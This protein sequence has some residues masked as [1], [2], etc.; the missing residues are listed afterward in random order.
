MP[1]TTEA[2][3][4]FAQAGGQILS[5]ILANNQANRAR[6]D[7]LAAGEN[8]LNYVDENNLPPGYLQNAY[9]ILLQEYFNNNQNYQN[10]FNGLQDMFYSGIGDYRNNFDRINTPNYDNPVLQYLRST[11]EEDRG[12]TN[13]A[14]EQFLQI[15][16]NGG[17]TPQ[18]EGLFDTFMQHGST[19]N[20]YIANL[21]DIG[22]NLLQTG[23][24]TPYSQ[25]ALDTSG[26]F[27]RNAG[28]DPNTQR[29]YDSGFQQRDV[30]AGGLT[31]ADNLYN[32]GQDTSNFGRSLIQDT[33]R[34]GGW[35]PNTFSQFQTGQSGLDWVRDYFTQIDPMS[36]LGPTGQQA[37]QQGMNNPYT[38][39]GFATTQSVL[40][41]VLNRPDISANDQ[42]LISS[43]FGKLFGGPDETMRTNAGIAQ[44]VAGQDINTLAPWFSQFSDQGNDLMNKVFSMISSPGSVGGGGGATAS[45]TPMSRDLGPVDPKV[46]EYFEKALAEFEKNPLLSDQD[47][48]SF[49]RDSASTAAQ[50][51]GLAAVKKA[52]AMGGPAPTIAGGGQMDS[53]IRSFADDSM[54]AQSQAMKDALLKNSELKL[55]RS[56]QQ[57]ELARALGALKAQREDLFGRMNIADA[58]N[59]TQ[60]SVANASAAE[61]AANR[62]TQAALAQAQNNRGLMEIASSIF[63]NLMGNATTQRG[64]NVQS[65]VAG[66]DALDS[67]YQSDTNRRKLF[68]DILNDATARGQ[69]QYQSNLKATT[70]LTG[71]LGQYG[72]Q[73]NTAIG[74]V[75]AALNSAAEQVTSRGNTMF[76]T[77]GKLMTNATDAA[78]NRY[79]TGMTAGANVMNTGANSMG[80]GVSGYN[81]AVKNMTDALGISQGALGAANDRLGHYADIFRTAS[82][83]AT[84]RMDLG[85]KMTGQG[86]DA[87]RGFLDSAAGVT[88]QQQ[89]YAAA[90]GTIGSNLYRTNTDAA[91]NYGNTAVGF[92]NNDTDNRK[93][94]NDSFLGFLNSLNTGIV[95][96]NTAWGLANAPYAGI[97]G[98]Q[99]NYLAGTQNLMGSGGYSGLFDGRV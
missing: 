19:A 68:A 49:A 70:D 67:L 23:G 4:Q 69:S 25:N 78:A 56:G 93:L 81:T 50:Q 11:L 54:K 55:A 2:I 20:P 37:V 46:Q 26:Y 45:Y 18:T 14:I 6:Q 24:M 77:Y 28:M 34:T 36:V 95:N 52:A 98:Q 96:N 3:A 29:L 59:A 7:R 8:I 10:Q 9:Q 42:A 21:V 83:D 88:K 40:N 84:N 99:I 87:L 1:G 13:P 27:F 71:Q 92:A 61:S 74:Q 41:D 97:L 82:T 73:Q 57:S 85:A 43:A 35:D 22:G 15:A 79:G 86:L 5:A 60:V 72:A 17:K 44:N 90:M 76:D 64:Q 63:G 53:A 89:D 51:A 38:Q 66:L 48:V 62:A 65:Q 58:S 47:V 94:M 31:R 32:Y 80:A 12:R 16:M 30:A 33:Q 91:G 39:Q 75:L